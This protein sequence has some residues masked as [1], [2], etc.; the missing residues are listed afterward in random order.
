MA[1]LAPRSTPLTIVS[2][3]VAGDDLESVAASAA[4]GLGCPVAIVLP[5]PGTLIVCPGAEHPPRAGRQLLDHA[6]ATIAG[7]APSAP[8]LV[9]DAVPIRIG[10]DVVGIVAALGDPGAGVDARAWLEAAAAAATVTA[11]IRETLDGEVESSRRAFLQTLSLAAP[12]DAATLVAQARRLGCELGAGAVALCAAWTE[13][14]S[15]RALPG[16]GSALIAEVSPGHVLGLV[17]LAP[18]GATGSGSALD[19]VR[20]AL[21]TAGLRVAVSLPH[22]DPA[23]L[24]QA[25]REAEVMLALASQPDAILAS[26]E[27]TYRLLIRVLLRDPGELE[28]LRSRTISAI[29]RYDSDHETE[30]LATLRAFL[31]HHGSTTETAEAMSLHRHTVGYR[32]VRVHEVSGL[33]PYESDGRERLSLGLKAHRILEADAGRPG[34]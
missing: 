25:L 17:A 19:R 4:A 14:G 2:A 30:L 10:P 23:T 8:G 11:L 28:Q 21:V 18:G 5:A 1:A 29:E 32:L 33:S 13:E 34:R 12:S 31:A 9:T 15:G 20:A 16:G 27:D 22:R 6:A 7:R 3:A 24:H 26:Q